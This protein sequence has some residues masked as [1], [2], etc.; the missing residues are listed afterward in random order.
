MLFT[1]LIIFFSILLLIQIFDNINKNT[2]IE[3]YE[4]TVIIKTDTDP[5]TTTSPDP[6]GEV[7]NNTTEINT[8]KATIDDQQKQIKDLKVQNDQIQSTINDMSQQQI[9]AANELPKA[10]PGVFT[11]TD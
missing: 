4:K 1:L 7:V 11:G 2:I 6:S 8:L 10:T 5:I 3:G 9:A